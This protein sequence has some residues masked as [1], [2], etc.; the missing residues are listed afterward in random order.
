MGASKKYLT[1][2][3]CKKWEVFRASQLHC[4]KCGHKYDHDADVSLWKGGWW[5][6]GGTGWDKNQC[7]GKDDNKNDNKKGEGK[8]WK[9]ARGD[10]V[11]DGP[12]AEGCQYLYASE[13]KCFE[14]VD[15]DLALMRHFESKDL[16]GMEAM[17]SLPRYLIFK[18]VFELICG[19]KFKP[20][21][22]EESLVKALDKARRDV[23]RTERAVDTASAARRAAQGELDRAVAALAE[24]D[25]EHKEAQAEKDRLDLKKAELVTRRTGVTLGANN[26]PVVVTVAQPSAVMEQHYNVYTKVLEESAAKRKSTVAQLS[27][28][29]S[30]IT[31]IKESLPV[32][33]E[34]DDSVDSNGR[35]RSP[36]PKVKEAKKRLEE[37]EVKRAALQD[38]TAKIDA[39]KEKLTP[40]LTQYRTLADQQNGVLAGMAAL[41]EQQKADEDIE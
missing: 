22:D 17:A 30:L 35:E 37:Q 34:N 38:V 8:G 1:C 21:D 26:P 32:P 36:V 2:T 11:N 20:V 3:S 31:T 10:L 27:T 33:D 40:L 14:L 25:A 19:R 5:V 39:E 41:V 24:A 16:A 18:P 23:T 6:S 7:K 28:V 12:L 29:D 15:C 9:G 13:A 4:S